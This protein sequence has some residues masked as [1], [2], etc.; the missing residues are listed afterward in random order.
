[1]MPPPSFGSKKK[2]KPGIIVEVGTAKVKPPRFGDEDPD[3][4]DET[5]TE[6]PDESKELG[7]DELPYAG[8]DHVEEHDETPMS[9]GK[10]SR[11]KALFIPASHH[12]GECVNY[13]PESG[14][15]SKVDGMFQPEDACL[16]MFKHISEVD[17]HTEPDADQMGGASDHDADNG[18]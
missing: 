16:R 6:D 18:Y 4:E 12:C 15:C 7:E 1:M 11:E 10:A 8:L 2:K 14:E 13:S 3:E 17:E 5:D 9:G